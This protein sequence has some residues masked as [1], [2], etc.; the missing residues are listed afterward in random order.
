MPIPNSIIANTPVENFS[1]RPRRLVK[2]NLG[3]LY[4]TPISTIEEAVSGIRKIL[5]EHEEVEQE[6]L[7]VYFDEFGDSALT[8]FI[9]Y[10][11]T[12]SNWSRYLGIKQGVNIQIMKLFEGLGVEFAYP[13]RTVWHKGDLGLGGMPKLSDGDIREGI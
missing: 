4:E 12:T 3:I 10:Y 8:I 11:T 2:Q 1:R 5:T 13:T 9:Y 6:P 7:L